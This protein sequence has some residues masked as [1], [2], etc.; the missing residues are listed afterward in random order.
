MLM[1]D[2]MK[3][4]DYPQRNGQAAVVNKTLLPILSKMVYEEPKKWDGT[5]Q[6]AL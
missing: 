1:L 3:S 6:L 4:I 2:H 5:Q